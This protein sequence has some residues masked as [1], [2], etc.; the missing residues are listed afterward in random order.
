MVIVRDKRGGLKKL[1]AVYTEG[2]IR[3]LFKK[4]RKIY[5][6]NSQSRN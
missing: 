5:I 1:P 4:F 2:V 3:G 6:R